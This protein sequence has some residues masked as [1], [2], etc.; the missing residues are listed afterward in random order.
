MSLSVKNVLCLS[1][2]LL[3][4][5]KNDSDKIK[6][7][8]APRSGPQ[9]IS[10][11]GYL[12]GTSPLSDNVTVPGTI[13]ANEVT[14]VHPEISGR[15]TYLNVAEGKA[16]G[17]GALIGRIYDGDLQAQL[18]KLQ[19]QLGLAQRTTQRYAE[20]LKIE[21]VSKQEY[22]VQ[23]LEI[24]NIRAD[25]DIVRSNIMRTRITAPFSG[26]LGL[27]N[28][29]PGAYVTPATVI[30]TIRQNSKLKIDFTVPESY[31]AKIKTGQLVDFTIEGSSKRHTARILATEMGLST[32]TRSLVSR[33]EIIGDDAE[34][35]PGVFVKVTTKFDPDPN[36]IMVPTNAVISTA[37][38]KQVAVLRDGKAD[39]ATVTTG[40][41]DSARVEILTG[42]QVGDTIVTS[43]L[44]SL[45]PG[46][47]VRITQLAK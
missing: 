45:K 28:V 9:V 14:E 6:P 37:R 3:A 21:G 32:D 30:T 36:A 26:T 23:A 1:M 39:F 38:A 13:I 47:A 7:G 33:A 20:L 44:M 35:L 2:L 34:L 17:K 10:A 15:L 16:V 24:S 12:V 5:C 46:T 11:T 43:A 31:A 4:A 22:D 18:K 41:R 19:V 40:A 25:M 42:L 27:K 8:D 29:S